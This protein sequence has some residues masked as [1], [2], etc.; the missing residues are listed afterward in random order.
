MMKKSS[1]AVLGRLFTD[2]SLT[3]QLIDSL[4]PGEKRFRVHLVPRICIFKHSLIL[5]AEFKRSSY[6]SGI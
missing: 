2:D 6:L 1:N 3:L 4:Y 5:I